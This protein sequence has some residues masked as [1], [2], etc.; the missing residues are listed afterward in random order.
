MALFHYSNSP[1]DEPCDDS[2]PGDTAAVGSFGVFV[3]VLAAAAEADQ[4]YSQNKEAQPETHCTNTCQK[5]QRLRPECGERKDCKKREISSV[6]VD[7]KM[8]LY[9]EKLD[10][11]ELFC[12]LYQ[13][14]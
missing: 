12:R 8:C 11:Q 2:N 10:D 6:Q 7:T 14:K 5:H 9:S 4:V 3:Y 1:N 13:Q